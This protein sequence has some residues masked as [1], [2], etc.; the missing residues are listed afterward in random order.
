MTEGIKHWHLMVLYLLPSCYENNIFSNIVQQGHVRI[1]DVLAAEFHRSYIMCIFS[2]IFK[3]PWFYSCSIT[4]NT[5]YLD[6]LSI[7]SL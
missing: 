3:T 1:L 5:K 7:I 2:E 6:I 4:L